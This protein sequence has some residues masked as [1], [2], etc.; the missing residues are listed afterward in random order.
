MKSRREEKKAEHAFPTICSLGKK[1]TE[2]KFKESKSRRKG[3]REDG[4]RREAE[5]GGKGEAE[6]ERKG[7]EEREVSF[8]DWVILRTIPRPTS[9]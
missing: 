2:R 5:G 6:R 1:K 7:E 9:N 8:S 4:G 3:E